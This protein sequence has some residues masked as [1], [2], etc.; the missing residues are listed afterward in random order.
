MND[1]TVSFAQEMKELLEPLLERIEPIL[2]GQPPELQGVLLA[3][4][5]ATWFAGFCDEH[6]PPIIESQFDAIRDLT[7]LYVMIKRRRMS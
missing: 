1:N 4:L 7:E 5:Q 3:D 6:R 2:N